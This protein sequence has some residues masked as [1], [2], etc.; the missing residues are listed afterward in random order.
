MERFHLHPGRSRGLHH[1]LNHHRRFFN[2]EIDSYLAQQQRVAERN[3]VGSALRCLNT[4]DPSDSEHVTLSHISVSD[5]SSCRRLHCNHTTCDRPA[6]SRIFVAHVNHMSGTRL[7]KVGETSVVHFA[8]TANPHLTADLTHRSRRPG[9]CHLVDL[10]T[11]PLCRNCRDDLVCDLV[12]GGT[13][14]QQ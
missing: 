14:S 2:G 6:P 12:I 13:T 7:V 9:K 5:R 8:S 4:S 10:V 1:G 11:C 3:D